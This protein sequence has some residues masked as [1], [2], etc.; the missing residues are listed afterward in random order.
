M[1]MVTSCV[2]MRHGYTATPWDKWQYHGTIN[3]NYRMTVRPE[4]AN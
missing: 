4:R 1:G 3:S 2:M